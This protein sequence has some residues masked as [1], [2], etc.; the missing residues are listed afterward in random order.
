MVW[1]YP[2]LCAP[3]PRF[4]D[5]W[6]DRQIRRLTAEDGVPCA[7]QSKGVSSQIGSDINRERWHRSAGRDDRAL[8][9]D[10][11][12]AVAEERSDYLPRPHRTASVGTS[13]QETVTED[14]DRASI[15]LDHDVTTLG[16][17]SYSG[18][19]EARHSVATSHPFV[20][21]VVHQSHHTQRTQPAYRRILIIDI[22]GH[23]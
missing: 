13:V 19:D 9:F 6:P 2:S 22:Y 15:G 17:I 16:H 18:Y 23:E 1:G 5:L 11:P 8:L 12:W 3:L 7:R 21:L 14:P 4:E 10:V 20:W